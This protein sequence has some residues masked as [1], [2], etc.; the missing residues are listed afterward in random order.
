MMLA[1]APRFRSFI[2]QKRA[3]RGNGVA[4]PEIKASQVRKDGIISEFVSGLALTID[5]Y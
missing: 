1:S 4:S 3:L 2:S 5:N